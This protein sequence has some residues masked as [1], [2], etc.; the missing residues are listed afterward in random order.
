MG[1]RLLLSASRCQGVSAARGGTHDAPLLGWGAS[2]DGAGGCAG[3]AMKECSPDAM[4]SS[5]G[6]G[7]KGCDLVDTRSSPGDWS[8]PQAVAALSNSGLRPHTAITLHLSKRCFSFV[9]P[10]ELLSSECYGFRNRWR[11]VNTRP[12]RCLP[13]ILSTGRRVHVHSP[14]SLSAKPR[15]PPIASE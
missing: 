14:G 13:Q 3:C 2:G 11:S 5:M 7:G 15:I 9:R 8:V 10:H 12:G 6:R 1:Y 4:L